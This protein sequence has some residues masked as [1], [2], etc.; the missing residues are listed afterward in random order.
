MPI[1]LRVAPALL[2]AASLSPARAEVFSS[3]DVSYFSVEGNT[4]AEIYHNILDRGP[5]VNGARALASISTRATEDADLHDDGGT[6]RMTDHVIRLDFRIQRPRIANENVL[7]SEDR[8]KWQQMNVF[9]AAH[10]DQHKKVWQGCAADLERRIDTLRTTTCDEFNRQAN[11]LWQEMLASCDKIQRSY[12]AEQSRAL[13]LQPF[14]LR[15]MQA[16]P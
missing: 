8:A 11:A 12:D 10:E 2:V 3:V 4:P 15:A 9:I 14:M 1:L 5:R 6:C 7:T 16:A 13:M